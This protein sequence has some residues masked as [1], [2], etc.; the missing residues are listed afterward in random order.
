MSVPAETPALVAQRLRRDAIGIELSA[1]YVRLGRE[2]LEADAGMFS[3]ITSGAAMPDAALPET[4][5]L[6]ALLEETAN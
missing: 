1:D 6:F 3:E 5:D 2:R 4:L